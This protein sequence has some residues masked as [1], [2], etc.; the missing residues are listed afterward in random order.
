MPMRCRAISSKYERIMRRALTAILIF[1]GASLAAQAQVQSV[2]LVTPRLFGHFVGDVLED[3]VDVRVDDGVELAPASVPQPG[4]LNQWLELSSSRVETQSD[5]GATLYRLYFAY[6]TFYPALDARQL[7]VPGFTLSFK[8]GDHIYPAQVPAWSFG[9]SPLREILPPAKASGGQYM[10]PD[11][12]P[13]YY[14][15]QRE[16]YLA[17]GLLVATLIA[18][19]LLAYHLAWWPF[20]ARAHRPFTEASRTIR[21]LFAG[22]EAGSA[23]RQA[24]VV[25]HRAVDSTAGRAIF[26]EDVPAFLAQHPAFARLGEQFRR[27]FASSQS[28]FFSDKPAAGI[29]AFSA[30]ELRQ[31]SDQ[32]AATERSAS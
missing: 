8:S 10:Q 7:D 6:Q 13:P 19:A 2:K 30:A 1:L 3:E 11:A 18:L 5:Q 23:Y 9:I 24:L 32:L 25:L 16:S 26:S 15:L 29:G 22:A 4:P 27:F 14:N 31:F 21:K 12:P 28:V 17:F 20:G